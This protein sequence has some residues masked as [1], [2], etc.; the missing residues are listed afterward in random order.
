MVLFLLTTKK[1]VVHLNNQNVMNNLN[2]VT[3][4]QQWLNQFDSIET[5][6]VSNSYEEKFTKK[7]KYGEYN[8]EV[9]HYTLTEEGR[10]EC[11]VVVNFNGNVK[12]E[13]TLPEYLNN[14]IEY[15]IDGMDGLLEDESQLEVRTKLTELGWNFE[16]VHIA[17]DEFTEV[18]FTKNGLRVI[19]T[20]VN[21][22]I[23][24]EMGTLTSLDYQKDTEV[25][26]DSMEDM[27]QSLSND[28]ELTK[29]KNQLNNK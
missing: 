7:G 9:L 1:G 21:G 15:C 19:L 4:E 14:C 25:M 5:P 22:E 18:N 10:D 2:S 17:S 3:T 11:E 28:T 27:Y 6:N 20:F 23:D 26:F 29:I 24:L 8:V 12:S 13:V 16:K